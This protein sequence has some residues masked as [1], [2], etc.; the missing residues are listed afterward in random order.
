MYILPYTSRGVR[1]NNRLADVRQLHPS[2]LLTP[3]PSYF[4]ALCTFSIY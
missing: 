4:L 1:H 3:N 2:Y